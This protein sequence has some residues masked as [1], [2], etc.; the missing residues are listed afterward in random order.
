MAALVAALA[1]SG[2]RNSNGTPVSGGLVYFT[3][4]GSTASVVPYQ[5][6][7]AT[8]S[9]ILSG[10]GVRLDAGGRVKVYLTEPADVRVEDA[11][12]VTVDTFLDPG[13]TADLMEVRNAGFTG[14][15]PV[16]N[17]IVAGGR[18]RLGTILSNLAAS[19]GGTDGYFRAAATGVLR[20]IQS[21]FSEQQVS[22]KDF[23]AVGNGL[24]DDTA[25]IQAAINFVASLSGGVVFVPRGT[26]LI[27]A[28]LSI[29]TAGVT[30][31]GVTS[32]NSGSVTG[33]LI[34]NTNATGGAIT[35]GVFGLDVLISRIAI[36]HSS[37]SSGLGISSSAPTGTLDHVDVR[38]HAS[39]I[40]GKFAYISNSSIANTTAAAAAAAL[41]PTGSSTVIIGGSLIGGTGGPG[42]SVAANSG[43]IVMVGVVVSTGSAGPSVSLAHTGPF[44]AVGVTDSGGTGLT[45]GSTVTTADVKSSAFSA[46]IDQRTGAPVNY[47]FAGANNMTPLP[48][49]ADVIRV[50]Q[51]TGAVVT[52]INNISAIGFAKSFTLIC[53]NTSAGASTFTFGGNYVLSAAVTPAA[54]TRVALHLYYDPVTSKCYEDGRGATAN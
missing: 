2:C 41:T 21:K 29:T 12:G 53:S 35:I 16:T 46:V 49:Q 8:S 13:D 36:D 7:D 23:G 43:T 52:T 3:R 11:A 32:V 10:G 48:L 51:S 44:M 25:A 15:D 14:T 38:G 47:V 27:S 33:S 5:D 30:L 1:F 4:P 6:R 22:V 37:S 17:A 26:Y 9:H 34:R 28:A 24:T 42:L 45:I 19:V 50:A 54:G 18:T 31:A 40:S 39:G 20:T